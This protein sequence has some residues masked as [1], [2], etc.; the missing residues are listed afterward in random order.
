MINAPIWN[1][2]S[3]VSYPSNP[4]SVYRADIAIVGGGLTGLSAAYHLSARYP[5]MRVVLLEALTLGAGASG[6]NTGMLSPGVGQNP[7]YLA[8]RLG[9]TCAAALYRA[10]LDAIKMVVD[11]IKS[12]T[13][14]CE[15]VMSGQIHW[16]RSLA[17]RHRLSLL[18]NWLDS[19]N[20][21]AH[22]L[23]DIGFTSRIQLPCANGS[24][25]E[26]PT[27]L[28]LPVAGI[29]N[30]YKLLTGLAK[31]ATS[32]GAIVFEGSPVLSIDGGTTNKSV[33]LNMGNGGQVTANQVIIATAGYTPALNILRG[34]IIPLK[35]QVLATEPLPKHLLG[36]FGW[37]GRE[38]IVEARRIFNYFRLTST[39]RLIFGG[40]A[41]LYCSADNTPFSSLTVNAK[42]QLMRELMTTFPDIELQN[43]RVT[44][45]WS[46]I[47]DYVL[48][49]LPTIARCIDRPRIIHA[50]GWCG[51]GLAL[52]IAA[53][54]WITD[55]FI[56]NFEQKKVVNFGSAGRDELPWFRNNPPKLPCEWLHKA[57]IKTTTSTMTAL[58]RF[59]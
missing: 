21:P 38:G 29:V 7:F 28:Y 22:S 42:S 40:G 34:R 3:E 31:A 39:N 48:D 12:E 58:D 19:Q 41:P 9:N 27:A 53:G 18:A 5:G 33:N 6:C 4:Q 50:V 14:D 47:I 8:K 24:E 49:G 56:N 43:I 55:S 25:H 17:G 32:R 10:T 26:G 44:H 46:G 35:L 37:V 54:L 1:E 36:K 51:H 15:L 57:V 13:I 20:L 30:P 59:I 11:L 2:L 16:A 52:S 45:A 23:D